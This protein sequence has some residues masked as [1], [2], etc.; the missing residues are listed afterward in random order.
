[1]TRQWWRQSTLPVVGEV[2]ALLV[3]AALNALSA[4]YHV[5]GE[6]LETT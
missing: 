5:P 2:G 6:R 3:P 1:M 4:K